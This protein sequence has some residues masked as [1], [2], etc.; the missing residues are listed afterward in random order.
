MK[1][2]LDEDIHVLNLIVMPNS[3]AWK[4]IKAYLKWTVDTERADASDYEIISEK[5]EQKNEI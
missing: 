4:R 2:S 5:V 1:Y 3:K